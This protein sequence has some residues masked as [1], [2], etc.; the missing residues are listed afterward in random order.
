[1]PAH[2]GA[3]RVGAVA[4][5]ID[6]ASLGDLS[7]LCLL[8]RHLL[9]LYERQKLNVKFHHSR[10]RTCEREMVGRVDCRTTTMTQRHRILLFVHGAC[11][12]CYRRLH[13]DRASTEYVECG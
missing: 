4:I 12:A 5:T 7:R 1:M 3:G 13:G 11:M 2:G 9:K 10:V 6:R 8:H